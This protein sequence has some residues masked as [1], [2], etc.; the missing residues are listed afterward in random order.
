MYSQESSCLVN[1]GITDT[2]HHTWPLIAILALL[3]P[4]L[5]T[6]MLI[7]VLMYLFII[8]RAH[9]HHVHLCGIQETAVVW[10]LCFHLH[11]GSEAGTQ[12]ARFAD[13]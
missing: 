12:A 3:S 1:V 9:M 2:C 10:I 7:Y 5:S 11:M 4:S 13:Y 8:L 6:K